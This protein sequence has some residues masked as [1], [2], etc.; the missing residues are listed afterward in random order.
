[1]YSGDMTTISVTDARSKLPELIDRARTEA[2]F[3]ER[4]G[5]TEAVLVSPEQYERLMD[6]LEEVED[7]RAY[8]EAMADEGPNIPWDQVK[9]DLGWE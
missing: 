9:T 6:A 7:V 5:K 3:V 2:V 4:H 8:D 1:M